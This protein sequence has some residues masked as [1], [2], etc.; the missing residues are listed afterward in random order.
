[1]INLTKK[2]LILGGTGD[3]VRLASQ[4]AALGFVVVS[5]LAGRTHQS[6][7]D[8]CSTEQIR[9]G[10]FGGVSGLGAY[11]HQEKIDLVIDAT[12]PFA[13]Q[14]S[15]NAAAATEHC[16]IPRLLL[17]RPGWEPVAGDRWF[18]VANHAAAAALLPGLAQRIFLTIG[19]Q[20]INNYAHLSDLWFLMRSIDPPPTPLPPGEILLA[21]GPFTLA[22]EQKLLVQHQIE[23]IVSKNS[24]GSATDAKIVAARELNLPI[25]M[26]QRP[27]IPDGLQVATVEEAVLWL[28]QQ[29]P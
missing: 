11:L 2:L 18:S 16:G 12:H 29:H 27:V 5:S 6:R 28:K 22:D 17:H 10:G 1:M 21:K 9:V 7:E 15:W 26:I 4:A 20:E 25:V 19:R 23:V 8:H 14:I 24:G 13:Q 3:A